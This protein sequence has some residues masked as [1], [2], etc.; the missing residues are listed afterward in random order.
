MAAKYRRCSYVT[1]FFV[2][3]AASSSFWPSTL[4]TSCTTSSAR[5]RA[6]RMRHVDCTAANGGRR[7]LHCIQSSMARTNHAYCDRFS[8]HLAV[9]TRA[10]PICWY[11]ARYKRFC[12]GLFALDG[13]MLLR[14]GRKCCSA[15]KQTVQSSDFEAATISC[16]QSSAFS[17]TRRWIDFMCDLSAYVSAAGCCRDDDDDED[18]SSESSSAAS[19]MPSFGCGLGGGRNFFDNRLMWSTTRRPAVRFPC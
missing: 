13:R 9:A 8:R 16:T 4:E 7:W 12:S 5:P 10:H 3:T 6:L 14:Y 17:T 19:A 1:P 15:L 11:R 18:F 2:T